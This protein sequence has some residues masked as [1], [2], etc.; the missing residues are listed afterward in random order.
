M[1]KIAISQI[2]IGTEIVLL[3][4]TEVHLLNDFG[5][6]TTTHE[7][8]NPQVAVVTKNLGKSL[9]VE[10][11]GKKWGISGSMNPGTLMLA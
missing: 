8:E 1:S 11:D 5:Q 2:P 10:F 7:I 6:P 9:E 4:R 3:P